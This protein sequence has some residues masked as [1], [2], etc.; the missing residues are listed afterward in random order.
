MEDGPELGGEDGVLHPWCVCGVGGE[1][2][3]LLEGGGGEDGLVPGAG[4]A[5]G[6]E[7]VM[8]GDGEE[9][10]FEELEGREYIV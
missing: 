4:D 3:A 7:E 6:N 10:G 5:D 9:D 2:E 1:E 8:L